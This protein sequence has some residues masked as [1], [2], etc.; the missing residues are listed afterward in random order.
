MQSVIDDIMGVD[1]SEAYHSHRDLTLYYINMVYRIW[2]GIKSC[3]TKLLYNLSDS[4]E[5][6]QYVYRESGFV[7]EYYAERFGCKE[8][9][10]DRGNNI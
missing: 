4:K 2:N 6:D 10:D 3:D 8:L 1:S 5:Y 9:L 7:W